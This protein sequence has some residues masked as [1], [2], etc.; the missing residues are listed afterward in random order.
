MKARDRIKKILARR[1]LVLDG[2]LGTELHKM[3]MPGGVSPEIWCM[4]NPAVISQIYSDYKEAGADILYTSS[5]G[6]N[7]EKLSQYNFDDVALLNKKLALIAK[8]VAGKDI[9]VAGDIGPTGRFIKPFG[10]LDFDKA[11][12]IFKEQAKGLLSGGVDLFVIETMMDV[13]E[14]RAALIAVKEVTDKFTMVTMTYEKHGRT[15]SGNDPVS[16]LITLQSLGADAVGCN[17]STGPKDMLKIISLMK[18]FK[19]VP[20]IAK[21]NAGVPKLL[22]NETVFDMT[23]YKFASFAGR[24]AASGVSMLGGC[25]GTTPEHIYRLKNALKGKK[26]DKAKK[27]Q[28]NGLSSPRSYFVFGNRRRCGIVGEKINPTGKKHLKHEL[29]CGKIGLVRDIAKEQETN[30][31]DLLDVNVGASGVDE[32]KAM[33][34]V[35]S[36]LSVSTKLP[37]VI[38]SSNARVMESA[39]RLYPGRALINSVSG[40]KNN[41]KNLL[42]IVKKYGAMFILLP[43]TDKGIP[44]TLR[45]RKSVIKKI[46]KKAQDLGIDKEDII[47]DGLVMAFS[48][49]QAAPIKTIKTVEW[50]SKTLRQKTIV[51]LSNISFGMPRRDLIN[52]AFLRIME[53]MGLTLAIADPSVRRIKSDRAA[54]RLLL[55]KD[56]DGLIFIARHAESPALKAKK[57]K[58]KSLN[59]GEKIFKAIMDGNKEGI[60][61][62]LRASV[63]GGEKALKL[64]EGH[65]IPAVIRVGELFDRKVY[66]LPQLIASAETMKKGFSFLE[67]YL[68]REAFDKRKKAI[69][70]M[71]TVKGDIH[72][73]GK[74]IV[75]LMLKNH[76]FRVIDLGKDVS[77]KKIIKEIKRHSPDM[78]GLSALMTTTMVNMRDVIELAENEGLD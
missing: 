62:S 76:S 49:D 44:S 63:R 29:S 68:K 56:N 59:Y 65:M 75:T 26:L 78:V 32:K 3:G 12:G 46:I 51:G 34:S 7:R 11:V 18:P 33:S 28:F 27:E 4:K 9:M 61:P 38:D 13:Q 74:N 22:G 52:A 73:I 10:E 36:T 57:K 21:P 17:C 2:A 30:G 8:K 66:F 1:I 39:L 14:A 71:A 69:I 55:G 43:L 60:L 16:A 15:L 67:P 35:I 54:E 50:C 6:A 58:I 47:V 31:A 42:P 20:L 40:E 5:F 23:P 64:L 25:C 37:L 70:L 72:D 24:F 53:N 48:A 41:L 45:E 19:K 77:A